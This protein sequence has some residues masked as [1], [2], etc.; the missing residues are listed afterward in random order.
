[1]KKRFL[2]V[3]LSAVLVMGALAG[4]S[5]SGSS[6]ET[7]AGAE[8]QQLR[9]QTQQQMLKALRLMKPSMHRLTFLHLKERR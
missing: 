7:T 6:S 4:C 5:G 8:S 9:R 3:M 2:G 1:M